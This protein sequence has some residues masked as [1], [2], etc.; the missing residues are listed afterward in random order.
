MKFP[1]LI[2]SV[3]LFFV[4]LIDRDQFPIVLLTILGRGSRI[5]G[6]GVSSRSS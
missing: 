2:L 5:E 6:S 1:M 3:P 4:M